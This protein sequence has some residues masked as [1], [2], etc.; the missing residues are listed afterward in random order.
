VGYTIK[1]PQFFQHFLTI[2][3]FGIISTLLAMTIQAIII[4]LLSQVVFTTLTPKDVLLITIVTS[5]TDPISALPLL[6]VHTMKCQ[7]PSHK[8]NAIVSG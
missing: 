1:K 2:V 7:T 5:T 4:Y 3:F 8:L 6:K